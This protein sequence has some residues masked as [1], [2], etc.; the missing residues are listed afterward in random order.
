MIS[1]L[2]SE[3]VIE[4]SQRGSKLK[5]TT[6]RSDWLLTNDRDYFRAG[7]IVETIG[8]C[9]I[10]RVDSCQGLSA[11]CVVECDDT[12]PDTL[13]GVWR[14]LADL[15]VSEFR[16]YL[17]GERQV[18]VLE[19]LGCDRTVEAAYHAKVDELAYRP[20][21]D[22]IKIRP[23]SRNDDAIK[24][25]LLNQDSARPDGKDSPAEDYIKLERCK[26]E[27]GYMKGF[28]IEVENEP[29]GFFSLSPQ[30]DLVRMKN[31]FTAPRIRGAGCGAAIVSFA[32]QYAAMTGREHIGVFAIQG[33]AGERLYARNGLKV[34]GAQTEYSA[35]VSSL[36]GAEK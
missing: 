4:A 6:R 9:R 30:G 36:V 35:S 16:T 7:A 23:I 3:R 18:E 21:P 19:A 14:R 32:H 2:E 20:I 1:N 10:V 25:A 29:A 24:V 11:A 12:D 34:V 31:L 13:R 17:R 26:I 33:G 22:H 28:L 27:A 8:G 15:N 5:N